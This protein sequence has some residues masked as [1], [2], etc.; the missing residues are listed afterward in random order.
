MGRETVF[1]AG[2]GEVAR[3][4]GSASDL[5]SRHG[6]ASDGEALIQAVQL[7][8]PAQLD[9]ARRLELNLAETQ[10]LDRE[11]VARVAGIEVGE[12]RDCVVRG[13]DSVVY[14]AVDRRGTLYHGTFDLS[15]PEQ[16]H[17]SER[18]AFADSPLG[19][20]LQERA[21]GAESAEQLAQKALLDSREAEIARRERDLKEQQARFEAKVAAA[22]EGGSSDAQQGEGS[23]EGGDGQGEQPPAVERPSFMRPEYDDADAKAAAEY[24]KALNDEQKAGLVA[25]ERATKNRKTVLE[26]AG[27]EWSESP[28]T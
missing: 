20:L 9:T 11:E 21:E 13:V 17:V 15:R 10:R 22:A 18:S 4:T 24:A 25:Y 3:Q 6:V 14:T 12:V 1:D 5:I 23:G 19:Q 8:N 27:A 7:S 28:A 16:S 2:V 26:A